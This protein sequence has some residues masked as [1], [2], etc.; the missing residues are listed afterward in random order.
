MRQKPLSKSNPYMR[1]ATE[2]SRRLRQQVIDSSAVEGIDP[3]RLDK[4]L[5]QVP[6]NIKNHH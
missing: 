5:P 3:H 4:V 6:E 2:R 1:D